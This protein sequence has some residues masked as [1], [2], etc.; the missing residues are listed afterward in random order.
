MYMR[1][2]YNMCII[3]IYYTAIYTI[4]IYIFMLLFCNAYNCQKSHCFIKMK[5]SIQNTNERDLT[6]I[7]PNY[8]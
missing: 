3:C 2:V 1:H 5:R 6:S 8:V 7:F 4:D